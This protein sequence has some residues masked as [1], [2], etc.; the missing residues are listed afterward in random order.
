MRQVN[1]FRLIA[2]TDFQ[3]LNIPA[4]SH[5][6]PNL[7]NTQCNAKSSLLET[8]TEMLFKTSFS[9]V[10]LIFEKEKKES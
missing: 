6:T 9:P 2:F 10:H 8:L 4:T 3:T 7:E 1:K 5:P